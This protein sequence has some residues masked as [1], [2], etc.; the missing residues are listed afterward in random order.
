MSISVVQTATSQTGTA[1]FASNVT[2]GN[3]VVLVAY[4]TATAGTVISVSGLKLGGQ[5]V[6]GSVV[7][8][9]FQS[10]NSGITSVGHS[11]WLM[12]NC[13]SGSSSVSWGFTPSG[14]GM[15]ATGTIAYEVAGLGNNPIVTM[16]NAATTTG[17]AVDS[18]ATGQLQ[19]A[20]EFVLAA[21]AIEGGS[22]S[23]PG[24]WTATNNGVNNYWAG[25][26]IA[27]SA[28]TSYD[29]AQTGSASNY[30]TAG[31]ISVRSNSGSAAPYRLFNGVNG[32]STPVNYSGNFISGVVWKTLAGNLW[33]EGYWWWVAQNSGGSDGFQ[34]TGPT[35]CALW[36]QAGL[37]GAAPT[38]VPN[39]VVTSGTLTAGQWNYIALPEPILLSVGTTYIAAIGCNGPFP[40]TNNTW[41][42]GQIYPAGIS[43]GPLNAYGKTGTNQAPYGNF[44]G[45]FSTTGNDP[46]TNCPEGG[47]NTDNFWVDVQ[48]TDQAPASY[49]GTY[50]LWPNNGGSQH[51]TSGDSA[52]NYVVGTEIDVS[53]PVTLNKIWYFSPTG[54]AQLATECGVWST[55]TQQLVAQNASP[56]WSGAA[57]SGW[58]S[59]SFNGAV[60]PPGKYR[61]TVY[62]GAAT[63][64]Q[65]SAKSLYYFLS[66]WSL[67]GDFPVCDGAS[68]ITSGPLYAPD[69]AN[70]QTANYYQQAGSGPGQAIFAVGPPNAYPNLYV[71]DLFQTYW[72]D[73]EVT[74]LAGTGS[75]MN[76]FP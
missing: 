50:R 41:G 23:A 68:G 49:T 15:T 40:D 20:N 42:A 12:P 56:S 48:I 30:W 71:D 35:K 11:I 5:S 4:A 17:T 6:N 14:T 7:L 44:Q 19:F 1:T 21:A 31:V 53:T 37:N 75:F 74:V 27:S 52:V 36:Q 3:S 9:G 72:V 63:P 61:V 39:S 62:N 29:W 38:L 65:W 18:G 33:F 66:G 34:N 45:V 16:G 60:I 46:S 58:V 51:L 55:T 22:A 70:A 8:Q 59:C 54:T 28:G 43:N 2:A 24:G 26:Q 32:P 25:Y 76:F 64:D 67:R 47:S 57:G 10:N 13:P 69:V 73:M